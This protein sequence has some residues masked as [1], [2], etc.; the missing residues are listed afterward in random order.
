[1]LHAHSGSNAGMSNTD[2][3]GAWNLLSYRE[4]C[5]YHLQEVWSLC[6]NRHELLFTKK[7]PTE[8]WLQEHPAC[9]HVRSAYTSDVKRIYKLL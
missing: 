1:M 6:A 8:T 5:A 7:Y 3:L 2:T 9:V 4:G